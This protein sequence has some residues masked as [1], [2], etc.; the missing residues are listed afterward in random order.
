MKRPSIVNFLQ[1]LISRP[2]LWFLAEYSF[3][4]QNFKNRIMKFP[5]K[6]WQTGATAARWG[7]EYTEDQ[8]GEEKKAET[9][10]GWRQFLRIGV[11]AGPAARWR[12]SRIRPTLPAPRLP[13]HRSSTQPP[14]RTSVCHFVSFSTPLAV[15]TGSGLMHFY[16][17][18][19]KAAELYKYIKTIFFICLKQLF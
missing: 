16:F 12:R 18:Y 13:P 8:S 3:K 7:G 2:K 1:K 11:T 10:D 19:F 9:S 15:Q 6:A 14:V 4:N 5:P 17:Y